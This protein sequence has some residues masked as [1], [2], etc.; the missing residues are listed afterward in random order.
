[1][2]NNT[3]DSHH[4]D[5]VSTIFQWSVPTKVKWSLA[6]LCGNLALDT[7]PFFHHLRSSGEHTVRRPF[8]HRMDEGPEEFKVCEPLRWCCENSS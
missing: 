4:V 3:D 2:D 8:H 1:M 5:D 7:R 6:I